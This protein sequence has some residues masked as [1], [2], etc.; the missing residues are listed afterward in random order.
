MT[1]VLVAAPTPLMRAGLHTLLATPDIQVVGEASTPDWLAQELSG[2]DVVVVHESLGEDAAR[3][4]GAGTGPL[5]AL[6][7]LS[8]DARLVATLRG[9]ALRSWGW[10]RPTPPRRP[11]RRRCWPWPRG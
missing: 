11:S 3:V 7:V 9:L 5:P 6:I 8:E 4:L 10:C 2:V 1:R